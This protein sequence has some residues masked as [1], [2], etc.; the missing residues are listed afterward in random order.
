MP[1]AFRELRRKTSL[2]D[3]P[4]DQLTPASGH[5]VVRLYPTI[6]TSRQSRDRGRRVNPPRASGRIAHRAIAAA[7]GPGLSSAGDSAVTAAIAA[8]RAASDRPESRPSAASASSVGTVPHPAACTRSAALSALTRSRPPTAMR[9][10]CSS[11]IRRAAASGRS[12]SVGSPSRSA[13]GAGMERLGSGLVEGS[14]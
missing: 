8:S 6:R 1:L 5:G 9:R 11:R 4:G 7:D 2:A 14:V 10:M 12:T 13:M 3:Q